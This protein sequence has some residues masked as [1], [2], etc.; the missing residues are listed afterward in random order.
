[1]RA[2]VGQFVEQLGKVEVNGACTNQYALFQF[3]KRKNQLRRH[4]LTRYLSAMEQSR[5]T[6][7]LVGEAPGYRG[8][9]LTGIPFTSS[10]TLVQEMVPGF[11]NGGALAGA[12]VEL[13]KEA[14]ATM[15]WSVLQ[16]LQSLP[17]LWNAFP[18]HPH[19]PNNPE[20]NRRPTSSELKQGGLFLLRLLD[21]FPDVQQ[22]AAVGN[23]AEISLRR[24][25]IPCAKLRHPSH[26]GK[27]LFTI[28]LTELM[29]NEN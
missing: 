15:V 6:L 1:M 22:I 16:S 12:G 21:L 8:C 19:R 14:T 9:R 17:L 4:N 26:G 5:P 27:A 10:H 23:S 3:E 20:S 2:G 28:G 24:L 11:E 13:Q 29:Q 18:F 25:G 7:L